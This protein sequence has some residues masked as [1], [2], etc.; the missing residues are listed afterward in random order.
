MA[1]YRR[2]S[3][4]NLKTCNIWWR[5]FN[6]KVC[7]CVTT[8]KSISS[9]DWCEQKDLGLSHHRSVQT[10]AGSH[11]NT[12]T[13]AQNTRWHGTPSQAD[14]LTVPL[15][16]NKYLCLQLHTL[17]QPLNFTR[18][19]YVSAPTA[20]AYTFSQTHTH[21]HA[22]IDA[23]AFKRW[24]KLFPWEGAVCPG[25]AVRVVSDSSPLPSTFSHNFRF[26]V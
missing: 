24:I 19:R 10:H 9:L 3:L 17:H 8:L 1:D 5:H 7:L 16:L 14:T 26:H 12:H 4:P 11:A 6:T 13:A 22:C 18:I 20:L 23:K 25:W 2:W 21:T 15:L